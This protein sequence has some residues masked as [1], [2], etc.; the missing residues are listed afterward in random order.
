MLRNPGPT[1]WIIAH[2]GASEEEP[3]NT[4]RAFR[5]AAELGADMVELDLHLSRDG[6]LVV[7]HDARVD[8]TTDGAGEVRALTLAELRRLDA[9]RGERI[10]TLQ[11]VIDALRSRCRLYIE[12]KAPGTPAAAAETIIRAGLGEDVI[13]GSF[14][15]RPGSRGACPAP[16]IATSLLVRA[17][18]TTRAA[19]RWPWAPRTPHLCWERWTSN[20]ADLLTPALLGRI[21]RPASASSSARGA[22]RGDRASAGSRWTASAAIVRTLRSLKFLPVTF[23]LP[24]RRVFEP[25]SYPNVWFY[26]DDRL[27]P[28]QDQAVRWLT[29]WLRDRC[30]IVDDFWAPQESEGCDAQARLGHVQPWRD[31]TDPGSGHA[32][33]LHVRYYHVA[34]RQRRGAGRSLLPVRGK[35][36]LRGGRTST[37]PPVRGRVPL[38]AAPATTRGPPTLCRRPRAARARALGAGTVRGEQVR[39]VDGTWSPGSSRSA[40]RTICESSGWRRVALT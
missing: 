2:R 34:L 18:G 19:L 23:D 3:E 36:A 16:E 29:G 27:A 5:R 21:G 40:R 11:E 32:H 35:R 26:V 39:R 38:C 13:I 14:Q 8:K 17:G 20:P 6:E 10:P 28:S 4:L 24:A 12:L 33:D 25:P 1:P 37:P 9:G 31:A 15:P 7:I 22:T 30:G